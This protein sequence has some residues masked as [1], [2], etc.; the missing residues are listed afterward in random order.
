MRRSFLP[1]AC[2]AAGA[3]LC[4]AASAPAAPAPPS[5]DLDKYLPDDA[6]FVGVVNVKKITAWPPFQKQFQDQFQQL[7]KTETAQ[8]VLKDTGF[9]PLRDLDRVLIVE[10]VSSYPETFTPSSSGHN[11]PTFFLAHG[12]FDPDKIASK[13]R[14][15]AKDTPGLVKSRKVEDIEMWEIGASG[16]SIFLA[17]FDKETVM[18]CDVESQATE[19]MEKAAGKK[20]TQLK[21]KRMQAQLT[22]SDPKLAVEWFGNG[23]MV[24]SASRWA[25]TQGHTGAERTFLRDQGIETTHGGVSLDNSDIH[26]R[27]DLP[28]CRRRQ[29]QGDGEGLER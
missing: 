3:L 6:V 14:Q 2:L 21:D 7:L 23:D 25:D 9:D 12:R 15:A 20:K 1:S 8:R 16:D 10:G 13:L 19:A 11:E 17:V 29:G 28:R 4:L 18:A 5:S 27:D 26:V 24:T 22:E